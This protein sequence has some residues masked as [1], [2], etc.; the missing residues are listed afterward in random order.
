MITRFHHWLFTPR[1]NAGLAIFRVFFGFLLFCEAFG[2]LATGWVYK[3]FVK[4]HLTIPFLG[5]D[6]LAEMIHGPVAYLWYGIMALLGIG[7]MLGYRYKLSL[8]LYGVMW[9]AVYLSQ[10]EHYNNHYYLMVVL[11]FLIVLLPAHRDFSLDSQRKPSI[12]SQYCP[13]WC[14]FVLIAL[15][16]IVYFFASINKIYPDWLEA[17]PIRSWFHAKRNYWLIGPLLVKDWMHWAVSYGGI[18]FDGLIVWALLWKRTRWFA[19]GINLFFHLFNSW[20]FQIGIFPYLMIA[21]TVLFFPPERV[22]NTVNRWFRK[23]SVPP[24]A[25][26]PTYPANPWITGALLV[27][28][29]LNF[30]FPLRHHLIEGDV[31]NTE[32]GHRMS[33][34]MMLRSKGGTLRFKVKNNVANTVEFTQMDTLLSR[35]QKRTVATHPDAAYWFIQKLKE[36]YTERGW[37]DFSIYAISDVRVNRRERFSQYD[38]NR[39]LAQVSWSHWKHNDWILEPTKN[40]EKSP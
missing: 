38:E 7:V 35:S 26:V 34:R 6:W 8:S 31:F 21:I 32:E 10:K 9:W 19:F 2:A 11:C 17:I 37:T 27:F 29:L 25:P 14:Y 39:D 16:A 13:N 20:V 15:L 3:V 4:T 5:F 28:L 24:S 12:K 22:R 23:K 1:D 30:G 40:P 36:H 18:L 33:W